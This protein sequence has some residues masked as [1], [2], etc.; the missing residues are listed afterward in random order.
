MISGTGE[1]PVITNATPL[2]ST[3]FGSTQDEEHNRSLFPL[4]TF[5][6]TPNTVQVTQNI[7]TQA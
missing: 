2:V 1:T 6:A 4:E 3:T 7:S 5:D